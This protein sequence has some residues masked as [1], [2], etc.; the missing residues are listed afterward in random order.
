M[1]NTQEKADS[2]KDPQ[3]S[4]GLP[5]PAIVLIAALTIFGAVTAVQWVLASLIGIIKFG[6]LL[7]VVVATIGWVISAKANR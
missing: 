6:L 3:H 7:V 4:N 5:F 2:G 1:G